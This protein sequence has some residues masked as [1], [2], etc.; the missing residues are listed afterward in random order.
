MHLKHMRFRTPIALS[1]GNTPLQCYNPDSGTKV[2]Y[3][4]L[5]QFVFSHCAS[6]VRHT[7]RENGGTML[8]LTAS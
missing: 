8:L 5:G 2:Q 6:L 4:L 7:A 1:W 3:L